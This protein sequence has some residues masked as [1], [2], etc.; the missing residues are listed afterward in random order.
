MKCQNLW[1]E[2]FLNSFIYYNLKDFV[3]I[4]TQTLVKKRPNLSLDRWRKSTYTDKLRLNYIKLDKEG[5]DV[6]N[7]N[8]TCLGPMLRLKGILHSNL[9]QTK[10]IVRCVVNKV[11]NNINLNYYYIILIKVRNDLKMVSLVCIYWT[12]F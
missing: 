4:F 1:V 8:R 3:S 11:M 9:K 7:L 10:H 6:C 5:Y 12:G 2:Y